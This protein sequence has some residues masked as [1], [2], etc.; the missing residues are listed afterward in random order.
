MTGPLINDANEQKSVRRPSLVSK[1]L[2]FVAYWLASV[3]TL[4]FVAY[5][6]RWI[7]RP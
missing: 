6:I 7:L 4:A 1:L 3:A 5:A 2:W